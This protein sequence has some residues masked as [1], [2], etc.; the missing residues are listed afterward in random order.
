MNDD[1]ALPSMCHRQ[2]DLYD[3][4]KKYFFGDRSGSYKVT[5]PLLPDRLKQASAP[6]IPLYTSPF[7]PRT[8]TNRS[9]T[10]GSRIRWSRTS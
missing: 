10:I 1:E 6:N 8:S 4:Q 7:D 3:T 5:C 9:R 2:G